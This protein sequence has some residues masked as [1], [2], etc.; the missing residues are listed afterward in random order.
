MAPPPPLT[1]TVSPTTATLGVGETVQFTSEVNRSNFSVVWYVNDVQGGNSS[2]GTISTSGLYTAPSNEPSPNPVTVKAIPDADKSKSATAS[3]TVIGTFTISP[4]SATVEVGK[5][6]QFTPNL[7]AGTWQVNNTTGGSAIVGTIST[8]GLYTAPASVPSPS[9]VTVKAYKQSDPTK[10]ATATVTIAPSTQPGDFTLTPTSATVAAGGTQQFT[11]SVGANW[12]VIG[13]G[14]SDSSTWGSISSS[15]LYTAPVIPPWTGSVTIKATSQADS[16]KT[17]TATVAVTFSNKS[18]Q[19]AYAFRYRAAETSGELFVFAAGRFTA[20]GSGSISSGVLDFVSLAGG[21]TTPVTAAPFTGS[22]TVKPDGRVTASFNVQVGGGTQTM[23]PRFV[24]LNSHSA[25]MISFDDTSCGW[26]LIEQQETSSFA[27]GLS[28]TYVFMFDGIESGDLAPYA[29]AGMFTTGASGALS[30]TEDLNFSG[31]A[32]ASGVPF[33]GTFGSPGA[34][35]G[36]GS[37]NLAV[38]NG[39]GAFV[40]YQLTA[41]SFVFT[42]MGG[43]QGGLVGVA[44]KRA[45]GA[46]FSTTSLNG[47]VGFFSQGYVPGSPDSATVFTAGRFLAN[48]TGSNSEGWITSN[49]DGTVVAGGGLGVNYAISSDGRGTATFAHPTGTIDVGF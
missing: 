37:L 41:D 1:I 39:S 23:P 11:A 40:Y 10:T 29:A 28:G 36:R 20:S 26:G 16:S 42:S 3:V 2:V 5:T 15:G 31:S 22:Y 24:L 4:T 38:P 27:A 12:Q 13:A 33:D 18:L 25:Q 35:S 6:Q 32:P 44:W 49:T 45:P 46:S 19:G 48:G 9:T 47:G 7:P 8:S 14:G 34:G 43:D 21:D 17:A 30:G